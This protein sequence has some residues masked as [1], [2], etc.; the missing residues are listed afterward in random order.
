MEELDLNN[1]KPKIFDIFIDRTICEQ[2]FKIAKFCS[3]NHGIY[4]FYFIN[5]KNI[6]KEKER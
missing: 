5:K 4:Y 2:I 3:I 6:K 1:V